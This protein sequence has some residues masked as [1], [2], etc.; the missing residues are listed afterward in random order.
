MHQY[1]STLT[2]VIELHTGSIIIIKNM[3]KKLENYITLIV[4]YR[5]IAKVIWERNRESGAREKET[6][7]HML[8]LR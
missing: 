8:C 2:C 1:V 5:L 3:I 7:L 4:I 6:L